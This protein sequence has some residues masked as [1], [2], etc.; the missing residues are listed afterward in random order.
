MNKKTI[1]Y[2]TGDYGK[3]LYSFLK[4]LNVKID[5]FCQTQFYWREFASGEK[6]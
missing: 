2:G 1:I 3:G 6:T 5:F 4:A